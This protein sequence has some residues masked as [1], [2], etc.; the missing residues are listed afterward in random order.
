M[1]EIIV[2]EDPK[3]RRLSLSTNKDTYLSLS[4][5]DG[6]FLSWSSNNSDEIFHLYK[7]DGVIHF[8]TNMPLSDA[9]EKFVEAIKETLKFLNN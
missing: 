9:A 1:A 2:F 7:K 5:D 3:K 4:T 6:T 8:D